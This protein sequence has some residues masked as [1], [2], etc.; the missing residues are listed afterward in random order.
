MEKELL[1]KKS[2]ELSDALKSIISQYMESI[3]NEM[4][5]AEYFAFIA[6]TMAVLIMEICFAAEVWGSGE[7]KIVNWK[8]MFK[9]IV[10]QSKLTMKG[11]KKRLAWMHSVYAMD[12]LKEKL[13]DLLVSL[14]K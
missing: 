9:F 2:L 4:T 13:D 1:V 11:N 12:N 7:D 14:P 3:D 8:K 5:D 10:K 6:N